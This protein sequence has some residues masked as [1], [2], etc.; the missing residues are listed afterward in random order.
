MYD[1]AGDH[2]SF[3]EKENTSFYLLFLMSNCRTLRFRSAGFLFACFAFPQHCEISSFLALPAVAVEK[4]VG[5]NEPPPFVI[6]FIL[7]SLP[8]S[9]TFQSSKTSRPEVGV[10]VHFLCHHLSE[11]E[12]ASAWGLPA[13][14]G[15]VCQQRTVV[16]G[17][18]CKRA[19]PTVGC[20]RS[21]WAV[22]KASEPAASEPVMSQLTSFHLVSA[23]VPT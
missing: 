17:H 10:Q 11:R 6:S 15:W 7:T 8:L 20:T 2:V 19:P 21:S 13:P 12:K 4:S 5:F 1:R 18:C 16:I 14:V 23:S 9:L 22:V 3:E